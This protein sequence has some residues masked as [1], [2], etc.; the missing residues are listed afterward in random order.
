[1]RYLILA[2]FLIA[3]IASAQ[4]KAPRKMSLPEAI[5]EVVP[6]VVQI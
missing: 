4:Q 6:S 5:Q 3:I 1:M 2:A